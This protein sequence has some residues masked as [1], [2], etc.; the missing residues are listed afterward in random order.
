MNELSKFPN[1]YRITEEILK[2]Y[3]FHNKFMT[4]RFKDVENDDLEAAE[5]LSKDI[6]DI[7][8]EE[9]ETYLHGYN[10]MCEAV[11]QEEIFFRRNGHYRY[12]N[13][14]DANVNVYQK[15]EVM[16]PYMRGLLVSQALWSNHLKIHH[17]YLGKLK[18]LKSKID[19]FVEV[20]TG[21]GMLLAGACRV[22]KNE[23][24]ISGWDISDSSLKE[25][26]KCL[27]KLKIS[28]EVQLLKRDF[29]EDTLGVNKV[30]FLVFSEILEHL[31]DPSRVLGELYGSIVKQ[32]YLFLN[33]PLNSPAPDHITNWESP[34]E[35]IAQ[36]TGAGFKI[37]D[38]CLA[39]ASNLTLE[40]ALK[41]KG[42]ISVSVL[43]QKVES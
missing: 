20:G 12:D 30:D 40:R 43:A 25:T 23:T 17:F 14:N 1:L 13:F 9:L 42:A 28:R 19:N 11:Q 22:L 35:L 26:E 33:A 7:A 36:I 32:G 8:G 39:P 29:T 21:H 37:V 3:P 27:S 2:L 41:L 15:V 5:S 18:S 38:T 16:A 6:L 34:E 24:K 10:W 4:K 31:E